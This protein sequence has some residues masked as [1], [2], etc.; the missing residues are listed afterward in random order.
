M[1]WSNTANIKGATGAAGPTGTQGI[2]GATGPTGAVGPAGLT[3]RATWAAASAYAVNDA[4][5]YL[6][7]SYRRKVAGTTATAPGSDSPNWEVISLKGDTGATGAT[8]PNH[9][10]VSSLPASPA[11][12]QE[13]YFQTA[14][15][16][17]AGVMW[18]LR[19]RSL[20][21]DGTANT[22]AYKWEYVGGAPL[23]GRP[24]AVYNTSSITYV[25]V[26]ATVTVPLA[27]DYQARQSGRGG[28]Q[29]MGQRM[30]TRVAASNGAVA[31]NPELVLIGSTNTSNDATDKNLASD[32]EITGIAAGGTL[33]FQARVDSGSIYVVHPALIVLP[34]RVG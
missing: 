1:P 5:N 2:Q 3:W 25:D 21:V 17:T 32:Y 31:N 14:A 28:T 23:V 10:L 30:Y 7:S 15:M 13:V 34:M 11:N 12:G 22:S 24:G 29:A 20:N 26:G 16:Q 6:G 27:G 4:V 18:H 9:P 19:Y 8:G 33:R